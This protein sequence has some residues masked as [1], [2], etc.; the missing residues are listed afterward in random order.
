MLKKLT[1]SLNLFS[2]SA[3][4]RYEL[5]IFNMK[6]LNRFFILGLAVSS[7]FFLSC[8]KDTVEEVA[9]DQDLL[10]ANGQIDFSNE[11]DF[12]TGL[13][14]SAENNSY[15]SKTGSTEKYFPQCATVTVDD[16]TPGVFPKVFTV[17]FGAGCLSNGINRSGIITITLT[18]YLANSGCVMTIERSNYYVNGRKIEGT[19]VY[20]NITS[21]PQVPKWTR[22]VSNG[23][24]TTLTGAIFT[25]SGTRTVQQTAGVNTLTL[26]DNIYEVLSGNHTVNRPNG[27]S[28]TVTIVT[29]LIK[30]YACNYISQGQLNLQGTFLDGILDYGD[31]TCDSQATYTHSNGAIYN[32]SL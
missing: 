23:Q 24:L 5:K 31:T 26:G 19:V 30:K 4:N 28:L 22:T 20:E 10:S 1:F 11:L 12:S 6:N 14:V 25:F 21:N 7:F 17:D 9:V 2:F 18:N 27:T 13:D 32:I 16:A 8:E 15:S 29:P 3:S